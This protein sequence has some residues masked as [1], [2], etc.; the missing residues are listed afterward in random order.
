MTDG[1]TRTR[2]A[3]SRRS[4]EDAGRRTLGVGAAF[5][6][7]ALCVACH[8]PLAIRNPFHGAPAQSAA[9]L[10]TKTLQVL[11]HHR[12]LQAVRRTCSAPLP[13][14]R[15][16]SRPGLGPPEI[17]KPSEDPCS[18]FRPQ[19]VV[20]HGATLNAYRRWVDDQVRDLP[21]PSKTATRAG[22]N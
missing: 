16:R 20:S 9:A 22:A 12:A 3:D 17:G 4:E 21:D 8:E 5:L 18:R 13:P 7:G 6:A 11:T 15:I 14:G 19:P 2:A 10:D 1:W